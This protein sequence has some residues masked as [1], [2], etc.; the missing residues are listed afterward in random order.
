MKLYVGN[1]SYDTNEDSLRSAF[2]ADGRGVTEVA[3]IT[4]RDTGRPRG[5]GF[6]DHEQRRR[7]PA[8][9]RS[10]ALDG[11]PTS[12][13][14]ASS[15]STKLKPRNDRGGGGGGRARRRRRRRRTLVASVPAIARSWER[16]WRSHFLWGR[17]TRSRRK[18]GQWP[19]A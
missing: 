10:E 16:R 13:G 5:F 17:L 2:E 7:P 9:Q 19:H 14:R 11:S 4:D 1:L 3:I 15:R 8:D 12:D 6:V 18:A